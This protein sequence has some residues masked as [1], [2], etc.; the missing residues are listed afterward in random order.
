MPRTLSVS[1]AAIPV[2][3]GQAALEPVRLSGHE[4]LNGLFAYELLLKTPD[5]LG[6]SGVSLAADFDL[7]AFIG[8][9]I[10]CEIELDGSIP[11]QINALITDAALW[12][13]EGRH[14]Q[15]KLTLRPWLHLATLRTDCRI[16]QDLNVVQILD[17]LLSG[18][19]F[20][21]D[22]RLIEH[23]PV[24]DYQTQFNESDFAFFTRLCQEWGISYHFEHSGGKHRLVLSDAMGAYGGCDPLY[25]QVEYHAPGWKIDAEYIHS[26]VPA[27]SLTSGAYAT[28]DYDYTRPRADLSVSR[29]DPRLT[30]QAGSEVYQ[31]HA[32]AG[33]S[34]Y[35]QP[36]AGAG[37]GAGSS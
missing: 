9:E 28:R 31:W 2:V 18:Y 13:E 8:R 19:A 6:L 21:V 24:R 1:S 4:G 37:A 26:F 16:F 3:L 35:A 30:G 10:S 7:D 5:A 32:E 12:G 33:G 36:H 11:R 15:Y 23:Y 14:A 29:L 27:H 17:A 22:K 25:Q 20:P 34:H